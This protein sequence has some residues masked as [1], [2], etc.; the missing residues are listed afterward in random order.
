MIFFIL[1]PLGF[2]YPLTNFEA[3]I[4]GE[5]FLLKEIFVMSFFIY[6]S[7]FCKNSNDNN[8]KLIV[9]TIGLIVLTFI[10]ELTILFYPFFFFVFYI[11]LK[12][13]LD[14]KK[15][16]KILFVSLILSL[17]VLIHIFLHGKYNFEILYQDIYKK[18]FIVIDDNDWWYGNWTKKSIF[19][20]LIFLREDFNFGMSLRYLF[21]SHPII[22]LTLYLLKNTNEK[23]IKYFFL[24]SI[25]S[26]SL[27]FFIAL[28]WARFLY[29]I[30]IFVLISFLQFFLQSKENKNLKIFSNIY[31]KTFLNKIKVKYIN[32][33]VALYCFSWSLK[34]TYWQNH[35]SFGPIK[36]IMKHFSFLLKQL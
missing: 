20:Q 1:S 7:E 33:F 15:F 18:F 17:I 26:S 21:Y 13:K 12:N 34:L 5:L 29:I 3:T 27:L 35:Y 2:I 10:Y 24:F 36:T 23:K 28:D 32:I 9:G 22:L 16:Y 25:I 11:S 6:Y 31:S 4:F 30:Y 14:R 8:N 19:D